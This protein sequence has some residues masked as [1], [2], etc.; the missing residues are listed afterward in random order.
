MTIRVRK[1]TVGTT[2]TPL[3]S[4]KAPAVIRITGGEPK[5][6][7]GGPD[8]NVT[9]KGTVDAFRSLAFAYTPRRP[10]DI[11]YGIVESG[12]QTVIAFEDGL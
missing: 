5:V 1:V 9:D 6:Y 3:T 11:L 12:T 2:A 8:V 10:S 7:V 4:G